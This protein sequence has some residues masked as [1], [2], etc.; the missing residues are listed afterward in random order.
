MLSRL[1]IPGIL[2]LL[3]LIWRV[4][5]AYRDVDW[6][7][8]YWLF[9]DFGYSLKIAKNIALGLGETF[10]GV[11]TTNGYQPL[12]V[13][14]MVPVF[15]VFK[16]NL[17][18]PVYVA[19]TMLALANVAT[20]GFIYAIVKRATKQESWALCALA[21]W[22]FN[23][24]VAK[25]GTNGLEGGLSTMMVAASMAFFC[26]MDHAALTSRDALKLGLL[27]G[28]SFL[29]R[30]DAVFLV[31]AV[32]LTVLATSGPSL[33]KRVGFATI[34]AAGFLMCALPYSIW[35]IV[36]FGS[37][38]PTSGQVTTGK[39]SLFD[40]AA[41][42]PAR[43]LANIEYGLFIVGRMLAGVTN[44][45]GVVSTAPVGR[46]LYIPFLT[47]L[48]FIGSACAAIRTTSGKA[49]SVAIAFVLLS[50]MYG[51]GYMIHTFVPFERYFLP[52][53]LAFTVLVPIA[54]HRVLPGRAPVAVLAGVLLLVSYLVSQPYVQPGQLYTPGW[55]RGIK[56][57]NRVASTG[58]TVAA[59]QSGNLGYF[60][61]K[62][63]AINLDGVVNL[64]AYQAK[65]SGHLDQYIKQNKVKYL[66]DEKIWIFRAADEIGPAEDRRKFYTQL[67][68]V[69]ASTDY[70]FSIYEL[71]GVDYS[72]ILKP[73]ASASWTL[74]PHE[75]MIDHTVLRSAT[76]GAR[77]EFVANKCFDLKF[78]R[79]DWSGIAKLHRDGV[80]LR[81][82][83][84][85]SAYHDPTYKVLI[86]QNAQPHTYTL[87]VSTQ[88][89]PASHGNEVWLD[90][91]LERETCAIG[92]N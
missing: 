23:L 85:Y 31:T 3:G 49:R 29:S 60:Y 67:R 65:R 6:I 82:I 57:L 43:L 32:L 77:L 72:A 71:T 63:R 24:A 38:L 17:I 33:R 1:A 47:L 55:Q 9:E 18:A 87:E 37:P 28:V 12:Y 91:V 80:F 11:V 45:G 81:D 30:V 21:F 39:S 84:L 64:D 14:L 58:D 53:V 4:F 51:F 10:D 40:L 16:H 22:M 68:Q 83:D 42:D 19:I 2:L 86:D 73:P 41:L 8:N 92:A 35:N 20:G 74:L 69:H 25:N 75:A 52:L 59:L 7:T 78:L 90:A 15:W 46:E 44:P 34:A 26:A 27:L 50:G 61:Q 89:N 88:R 48:V 5:F 62:G 70:A 66:A 13:W 56:E 36:H 79:H 76:I 54:L